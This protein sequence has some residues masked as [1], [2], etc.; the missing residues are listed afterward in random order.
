MSKSLQYASYYSPSFSYFNF[1]IE[2]LVCMGQIQALV[3]AGQRC[4]HSTI[5]YS[6][7][8]TLL[9][10]INIL[11]TAKTSR[12]L[13]VFEADISKHLETQALIEKEEVC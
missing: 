13:N 6:N 11:N 3:G 1:I 9:G 2:I 12:P 5:W 4:L 8:S 7:Y 10:R